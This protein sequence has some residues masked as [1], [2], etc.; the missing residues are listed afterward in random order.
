TTEQ[1]AA[2]M[3]PYHRAVNAS[4]DA[5]RLDFIDHVEGG[6]A[7]PKSD[8]APL[9]GKLKEAYELRRKKLE[10]MPSTAQADFIENY[11]PHMWQDPNAARAPASEGR[12][13]AGKQGSGASLKKR[14][15]PTISDGLAQGLKPVTT[16]PIETTMRY[17]S[18]MDKFIAQQE[19]FQ[20]AKDAGIIKY[21]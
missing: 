4:T 14:S 7:T 2:E 19:V 5:E 9:A 18:S 12:G 6:S 15:I 16:D 10:A 8:L 21:A 11:Y 1:T 13:G 20:A 17:V 3:E